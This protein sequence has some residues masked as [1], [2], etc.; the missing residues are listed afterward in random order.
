MKKHSEDTP[1]WDIQ[2]NRIIGL[3]ELSIRKSYF[4]ELQQ[5]ILELEKKNRELRVAYEEQT[6]IGEKLR[7]QY[8]ETAKKEGQL[9]ESEER[10]RNLIESSPIP[11]VLTR[12][13]VFIYVNSAFCQ[14]TGY[15]GP[16]DIIGKD[17]LAF[18]APEYRQKIAG[19]VAARESGAFAE[20]HYESIGIRRDGT[21]FPYEITLAVIDLPEGLVTM[22]FISDITQRVRTAEELTRSGA[23]LRRAELIAG[24]GHWEF[25]LATQNVHASEGARTI[26]GLS[27]KNYSIPEVQKI[28]LPEFRPLLDK[29]LKDLIEENK[30]YDVEFRIRHPNDGKIVDIHSTAEYDPKARSVFG[31]I[32]DVSDRK[33]AE[34]NLRENEAFLSSILENLPDMIFVKDAEDLRFVRLNKAGEQLLGYKREEIYGK[35]DFELFP[36]KDAD[37]YNKKDQDVLNSRHAIDI[38]EERIQTRIKGIRSLHTKKIPIFDEMGNARYLL[39]IS[40]DITEYKQTEEALKLA[41]HKLSL[42]NAVTFEDIQTAAFSLTAYHELMKTIVTDEKQKSYLEKQ[43]SANQKIIDTLNFAKNYQDMGIQSPRWQDVGQVFLFAISH[44]DFLNIRHDCRIQGLQI[45]ADP[46]FEKVLFHLMQNVIKHGVH[47]T[48]VTISSQKRSDGLVLI[49]EDNGVGI[50]A[51][52]KHMIFDRGYGKHTGLGLFL[53]RE[54]LSITG[55]TIKETGEQ[56]RGARFEISV[57][58]GNYRF[59]KKP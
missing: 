18:V 39:G 51:G 46:L 14:M 32:Q 41:R 11:V 38:P 27:E 23:R 1:D 53:V 10:F 16:A 42:L 20:K 45:Y 24:L 34:E 7:H 49:I 43:T 35:N 25:D 5:R 48:E 6:A 44:L 55:L 12:G 2:R 21:R 4:P 52:E 15:E 28:P 19:N 50:P 29:A 54:V 8:E 22:A 9:H 56:N 13:G 47:V 40:E 57:P 17:L 3:G 30:P 31:V 58:K 33:R 26:Y 37:F 36:K 59:D